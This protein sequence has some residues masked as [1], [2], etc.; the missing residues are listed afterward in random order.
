[1]LPL[2]C[3]LV[4]KK[5]GKQKI[6][7][8][9]SGIQCTF[10]ILLT[11]YKYYLEYSTSPKKGE[12]KCFFCLEFWD[13][14]PIT[15]KSLFWKPSKTHMLYRANKYEVAVT[16]WLLMKAYLLMVSITNLNGILEVRV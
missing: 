15:V 9:F 2:S 3:N 5:T 1:M 12:I 13:T 8:F 6:L 16:H 14:F 11:L 7:T 10:R 4:R